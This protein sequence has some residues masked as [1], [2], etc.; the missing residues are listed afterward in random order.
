MLWLSA[1]F[2]FCLLLDCFCLVAFV[3]AD[4]YSCLSWLGALVYSLLVLY[5]VLLSGFRVPFFL[6]VGSGLGSLVGLAQWS[7]GPLVHWSPGPAGPQPPPLSFSA[8][9]PRAAR[10]AGHRRAALEKFGSGFTQCAH[11]MNTDRHK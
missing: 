9:L 8:R 11:V 6:K 1:V 2:V 4:R 10:V 5:L 7:P 3:P